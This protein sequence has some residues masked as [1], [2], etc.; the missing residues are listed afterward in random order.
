MITPNTGERLIADEARRIYAEAELRT[1]E[2]LVKYIKKDTDGEAY[3]QLWAQRKL[4]DIRNL[5]GEI[6]EDVI[7]YLQNFDDDVMDAIEEAYKLGQ[8]S[9]EVDLKKA[10]ELKFSGGL[11]ATNQRTVEALA[12]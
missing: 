12:G 4:A 7:A 5:R 10:G 8:K 9:A 1:I 11:T 2:K 6:N 3:G